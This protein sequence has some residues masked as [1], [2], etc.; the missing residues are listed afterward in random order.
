VAA[1]LEQF[2]D[3]GGLNAGF[4]MCIRGR[5]IAQA[6]YRK[7][8]AAQRALRKEQR[9]RRRK[10]S[11]NYEAAKCAAEA[12]DVRTARWREPRNR[13]EPAAHVTRLRP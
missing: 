3:I 7:S 1:V 12:P 8:V 6:S 5:V 11:P 9:T 4:V 2:L 13:Q 10:R